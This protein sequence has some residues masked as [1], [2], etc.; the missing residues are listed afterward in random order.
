VSPALVDVVAGLAMLVLLA[1][2]FT[3]PRAG[4]EVAV[5]LLAAGAVLAT[6]AV[7]LT[8]ALEEVLLLAPVVLFLA[9]ILVVAEVCAAE[10]LFVAVGAILARAGRHRPVRMLTLTFVAASLTT[11]AL[12]LDAT[13]VLL[14]PVVATAAT[15]ALLEPRPMV[16]ACARLANTASLLLPVSNLTNLLA[17][18]SLPSV[19]FLGFAAVMAPVWLAVIAVEYVGHRVY[20]ARDLATVPATRAAPD[21]VDLPKAPLVV[22]AL[23]LVSFAASSPWGVQPA[24]VAGVAA[25]A[26]GASAA[27]RGRIDGRTLVRSAHLPFVVFVLCLGVVVAGLAD[28]FLGDLVR[29]ALPSTGSGLG[30]LLLVGLLATGLANLV[31]NLPATLLLVPLVAPLGVTAVFSALIGL[32]VGSG[33]TYPG[34]LANLLWRRT[35]V[36]RGEVA[37]ARTFHRLSAVVTLPAVV[38]GV[39]VLWAWAPIVR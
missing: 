12:S 27:A 28:T 7:D 16:H 20:F 19:S 13:V 25:A 11:A 34:S 22:V 14:T 17:L 35:L 6:G 23:M 30:A 8:G 9:A 38:V 24:W 1:V 31:N 3:H 26:L 4:V 33:L 18:P 21:P 37:S 10:G 29:S 39:I 2:A 15:G 5:G 32:G 36:H